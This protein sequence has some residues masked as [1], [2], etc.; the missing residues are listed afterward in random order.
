[1]HKNLWKNHFKEKFN[2]DRLLN[3]M[4]WCG[5]CF[6]TS[7]AGQIEPNREDMEQLVKAM[8]HEE[9]SHAVFK[10][11]SYKDGTIFYKDKYNNQISFYI[12][13]WG[14]LTSSGIPEDLAVKIQ[15]S[16]GAYIITCM[17]DVT[18]KEKQ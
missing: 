5:N 3:G 12:R 6:V 9:Y 1:M 8:N 4:I 14:Y 15:D 2:L 17:H 18:M 7:D 11:P 13:G 16:L 10:E